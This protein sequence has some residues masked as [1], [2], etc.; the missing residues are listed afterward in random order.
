M[1]APDGQHCFII[2]IGS[3][4]AHFHTV[5]WNV[6]TRYGAQNHNALTIRGGD[7]MIGYS[8]SINERIL[9]Y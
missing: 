1:A 8:A 6:Y 7:I 2:I 3:Y 5:Q 9:V 4:L